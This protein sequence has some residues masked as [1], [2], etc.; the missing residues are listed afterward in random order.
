MA[1]VTRLMALP[2]PA[3]SSLQKP[4]QWESIDRKLPRKA[5]GSVLAIPTGNSDTPFL[6]GVGSN[7][8]YRVDCCAGVF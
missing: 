2:L 6:K 4:E 5:G 3:A 1:P 7:P 8:P